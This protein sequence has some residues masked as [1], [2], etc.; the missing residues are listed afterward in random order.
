MVVLRSLIFSVMG[1]NCRVVKRCMLMVLTIH[2]T[3]AGFCF[4]LFCVSNP[5]TRKEK[6]RQERE[7]TTIKIGQAKRQYKTGHDRTRQDTQRQDK[8]Q[9][10][11]VHDP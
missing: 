6:T 7:E 10:K 4:V 3:R 11:T 8:K 2:L 1:E 9:E 5:N